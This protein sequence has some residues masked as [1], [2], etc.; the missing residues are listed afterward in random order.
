MYEDNEGDPWDLLVQTV[1]KV[2]QL[3]TAL[4]QLV[5]SHHQQMDIIS[6]LLHQNQQLSV[7]AKELTDYVTRK[8]RT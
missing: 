5:K 4:E 1:Y 6:Q 8:P 7:Q 2:Q 3:E